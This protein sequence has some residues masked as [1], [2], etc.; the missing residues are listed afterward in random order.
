MTV[1]ASG[2]KAGFLQRPRFKERLRPTM[3][4]KS[5]KS[6]LKA[7]KKKMKKTARAQKKT[8]KN[9]LITRNSELP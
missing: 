4:Q 1:V 9:R 2:A 5:Q 7:P 3:E 6:V 8:R